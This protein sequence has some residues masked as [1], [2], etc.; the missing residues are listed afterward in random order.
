MNQDKWD[1]RFMRLA[2]EVASWSKDPSTKVGAVIVKGN[3]VVSLGFNGFGRHDSDHVI[4]YHNR[5]EKLSR[6]IHAEMN[7]ALEAKESLNGA[8]LYTWPVGCC[9]RCSAHM[10]HVG[11]RRFVAPPTPFEFQERWE[12]SLRRSA[13]YCAEAG[14]TTVSFGVDLDQPEK[15]EPLF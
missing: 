14:A 15:E 10:L 4:H 13:L 1:R 7:A 5:D 9:D 12:L 6:M 11:I 2:R 3:R 8:T